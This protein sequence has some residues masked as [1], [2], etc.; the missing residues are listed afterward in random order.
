VAEPPK[1]EWYQAPIDGQRCLRVEGRLRRVK[2]PLPAEPP[3]DVPP[4]ACFLC[5][6]ERDRFDLG[7]WP[8]GGTLRVVGNAHAFADRAL[9]LAPHGESL[10]D[11][12]PTTLPV[13]SLAALLRAPFDAEFRRAHSLDELALHAFVNVGVRAAQSRRHPHVQVVGFDRARASA[14]GACADAAAIAADLASARSEQRVVELAGA[15]GRASLVVPRAPGMTA[16]VW[17]EVAK[18]TGRAEPRDGSSDASWLELARAVQ[19][20]CAACERGLSGSYNLILRLDEPRLVRLVPRGLSERAG[21]ELAAPSFVGSVV[22]ATV[23]ET[24]LFWESARS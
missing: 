9:L 20:A 7:E 14:G 19:L 21:L 5:H 23:R 22:A 11:A 2:L 12:T 16:E 17:V 1:F 15:G 10:H 24:T 8:R 4:A 3:K 18:T 13:E 6:P